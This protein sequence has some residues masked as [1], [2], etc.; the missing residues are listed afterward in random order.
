M[1]KVPHFDNSFFRTP[2]NKPKTPLDIEISRV[3][4]KKKSITFFRFTRPD[5]FVL[6]GHVALTG[7][8]KDL[9]GPLTGT[10]FA[11][12]YGFFASVFF[13]AKKFKF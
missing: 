13:C 7:S 11:S 10:T 3:K 6:Y 2:Q 4:H 1:A 12:D 8:K 5:N 9:W